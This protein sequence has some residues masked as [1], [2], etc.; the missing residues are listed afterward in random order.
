MGIPPR[1]R[2][3]VDMSG[4]AKATDSAGT[5]FLL[6]VLTMVKSHL[7]ASPARAEVLA[8]LPPTFVAVGDIDLFIGE[9]M[10][11]VRKLIRDC[12]PTEFHFI[13]E[14][15]AVS[16]LGPPTRKLRADASVSTRDAI[17]RHFRTAPVDP[18]SV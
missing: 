1:C 11:F 3:P 14:P 16:R 5:P 2:S 9:D 18:D 15:P 8:G 10:E 6:E 12:V 13:V 7:Y 4:I 17:I